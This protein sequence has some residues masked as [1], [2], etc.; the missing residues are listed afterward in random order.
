MMVEWLELNSYA[1]GKLSPHTLRSY[2]KGVECYLEDCGPILS[3]TP[4]SM[5]LWRN[6]LVEKG[7]CA[8]SV[9]LRMIA[10]KQFYKALH[11]NG[12]EDLR[13]FNGVR[14][15]RDP[16]PSWEKREAYSEE[17]VAKLLE[18][19]RPQ[20]RLLILLCGHAGLRISE[21]LGLSWNK[22][23]LKTRK[24]T[25]IGKGR[26]QRTV[27]LSRTLVGVLEG[28]ERSEG[29]LVGYKTQ[30]NAYVRIQR[31][32]VAAGVPMRGLHSLRHY[33]GTKIMRATNSLE[34]VARMLGHA[35]LEM[36]R[37]Y[38]KWTDEGLKDAV[39]AW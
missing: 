31:L 9:S 11:D 14:A 15:P 20:D 32:C 39:A 26:K 2:K 36:A 18:F 21:A 38:A 1:G 4:K 34:N 7:L 6:A 28:M 5:K 22:I 33:A 19:A 25:V 27:P 16:T 35:N 10:V 12:F 3:A 17:E 8:K 24:L 23:D 37:T 29:T 30:R 13:P